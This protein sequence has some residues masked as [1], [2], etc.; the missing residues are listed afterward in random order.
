VGAL[1]SADELGAKDFGAGIVLAASG[2]SGAAPIS[3]SFT[4]RYFEEAD[5]AKNTWRWGIVDERGAQDGGIGE[6][7]GA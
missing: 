1:V 2:R 4:L 7:G 6:C 5:A 3:F